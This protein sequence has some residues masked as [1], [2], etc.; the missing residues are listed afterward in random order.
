L[1]LFRP[2]SACDMKKPGKYA[3]LYWAH[4]NGNGVRKAWRQALCHDCLMENFASLLGNTN[5]DSM[6]AST[7]P[8]CGGTSA[9]DLDPV[10]LT[11]FLPKRE[12]KEFELATCAACA[13]NLLPLTQVGATDLPNR[14][15][16]TGAP[17]PTEPSEWSDLPF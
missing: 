10:F 15:A 6:G 9:T 3:S 1:S 2:C 17:S 12:P 4:F 14:Q 5:S 16:G 11:L 7:C 8:A 13:A